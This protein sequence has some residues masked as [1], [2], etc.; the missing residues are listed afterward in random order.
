[1]KK[2]IFFIYVNAILFSL[3]KVN[4]GILFSY[5]DMD[6]KSVFLVGSMNEWNISASPM[7]KDSDGIWKIIKITIFIRI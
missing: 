3:E 4:D 1:M 2:I 7:E 5:N 6:A